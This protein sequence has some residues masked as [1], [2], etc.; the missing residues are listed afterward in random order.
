MGLVQAPY[1]PGGENHGGLYQ[2]GEE[3][4]ASPLCPILP[5]SSTTCFLQR[6]VG[7]SCP[8]VLYM[9]SV[10]CVHSPLHSFRHLRYHPHLQ[11]Y[12]ALNALHIYW[13]GIKA[14]RSKLAWSSSSCCISFDFWLLPVFPAAQAQ[15]QHL[16]CTSTHG[17]HAHT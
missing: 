16:C 15:L 8:T 5:V 12:I 14:W 1:I 13:I 10:A 9:Q 2:C 17:P 6:L 7:W 11:G 4:L 3:P